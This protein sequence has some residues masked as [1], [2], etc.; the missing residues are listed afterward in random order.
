LKVNTY[1]IKPVT[2]IASVT[3]FFEHNDVFSSFFLEWNRNNFTLEP[4]PHSAF[5]SL[6]GIRL[7]SANHTKLLCVLEGIV[8]VLS[9]IFVKIESGWKYNITVT[10][11]VYLILKHNTLLL[12]TFSYIHRIIW[13]LILWARTPRWL[14]F[15]VKCVICQLYHSENK[16]HFNEIMMMMSAL[17]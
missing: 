6:E 17:Y 3:I 15:K 14:L 16:L 1:A 2:I 5:Y 7:I 10:L 8:E 13:K 11:S 4:G 12:Q 9:F